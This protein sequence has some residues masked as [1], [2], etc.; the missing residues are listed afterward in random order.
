[1]RRR[2]FITLLGSAAAV[3]P[4]A[5]RA[6]QSERMRR[7]G[8]LMNI[9]ADDPEAQSRMTAFVQGLQQSGWTDGRNIRIDYRWSA[10][11]ADLI[12]KL[13]ME[14][15]ALGPDVVMAPHR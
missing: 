4:V 13:A 15:I 2:D 3:W 7:I 8:V 11:D 9:S 6:Q 10:G 12:R 1:M 5:T 14:M